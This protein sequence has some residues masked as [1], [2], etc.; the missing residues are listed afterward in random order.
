M[1]LE[2]IGIG[3]IIPIINIFTQDQ[4]FFPKIEFLNNLELNKYPKKNLIILSLLCLIV[5]YLFKTIFLTYVSYKQTKFITDINKSVSE[6]LFVNYLNRSYEFFLNKNSSE[7]IRNIN[8]ISNFCVLIRSVLMF[9]TEITILVGISLLLIIYEPLGSIVTLLVISIIGIL[10]SN[11]IKKK[12]EFWGEERRDADGYKQKIM[13]E[14]FRL[15]KEIKI[16]NLNKYFISKFVSSNNTSASNQFKHEFVLSLPRYWFELIAIF[17]FTI[18]ILVL[19]YVSHADDNIITTLGL[20]AAATFRLLPSVIRIINNIQQI[21][22]SLPVLN[23]LSQAFDLEKKVKRNNIDL[24]TKLIMKNDLIL[25]NISFKYQNSNNIVLDNIN[26]KIKIG[27]IMGIKGPTGVG[28]TTL[29]NIIL[30]LLKPTSGKVL[31]DGVEIHENLQS[32]QEIIGYVPQNIVL[33]DDSLI[34]NIALGVE[35]N[36]INKN[37]VLN[38]IKDSQ[39]DSFMSSIQKGINTKVG[40]LGSRL[41]GGQTQRIGIARSIYNNPQVLILD[42]FTSALDI[43]TE[44]KII[45]E[46][47]NYRKTKTIIMISHKLSTLSKCDKVYELT[48]EGFKL[49]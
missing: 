8:D 18:L 48:K 42:E 27:S 12:A 39:L 21:H 30:G 16:S 26:L 49:L 14:S 4:I 40:E 35:K 28:K 2:M 10:F 20:F 37:Q 46:I 19:T 45:N 17:G 33:T 36:Q 1:I 11:N 23:N 22:F 7:L 25:E 9:L 15:I 24:S 29:V 34:N 32:W 6:R 5:V 47:S 41:S 44:E 31:V 3:L 43:N 38:C 13:Q